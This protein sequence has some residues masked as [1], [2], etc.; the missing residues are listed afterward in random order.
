MGDQKGKTLHY[1]TTIKEQSLRRGEE[2]SVRKK[3]MSLPSSCPLCGAD[4]AEQT[5]VPS[6]VYGAERY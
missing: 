6:H 5:V 3:G 1:I 4:K 2:R